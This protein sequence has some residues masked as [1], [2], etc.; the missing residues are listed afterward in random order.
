MRATL[1]RRAFS[2]GFALGI[3]A[4]LL[5]ATATS[6]SILDPNGTGMDLESA[7]LRVSPHYL[8]DLLL[9]T[10]MEDGWSLSRWENVRNS[11]YFTSVGA[12]N[13]M[14]TGSDTPLGAYSIYLAPAGTRAGS[15]MAKQKW[16]DTTSDVVTRD[17]GGYAAEVLVYEDGEDHALAHVPIGNV[18]ILGY[19]VDEAGMATADV[20][21]SA[22]NAER[23]VAHLR[24]LLTVSR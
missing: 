22:A 7:L 11:P 14:A 2:A 4:A 13:V 16:E 3:P 20:E 8:R 24:N 10:P 18:M 15:Y 9:S 12:V 19:D 17:I 5:G 1:T 21:Q 6:Q 23:L